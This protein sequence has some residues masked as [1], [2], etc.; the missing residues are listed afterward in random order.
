MCVAFPCLIDFAALAALT[1]L[2]ATAT[3]SAAD[4]HKKDKRR[5]VDASFDEV[6][7]AGDMLTID[8]AV[9]RCLLQQRAC[10]IFP[11]CNKPLTSINCKAEKFTINQTDGQTDRQRLP[12]KLLLLFVGNSMRLA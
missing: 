7:K 12:S 11:G 4:N 6:A 8:D 9:L 1:A 10:S 5:Q 2:T 3:A